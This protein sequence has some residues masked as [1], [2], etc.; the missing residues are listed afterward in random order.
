MEKADTVLPQKD[1]RIVWY[2]R[3]EGTIVPLAMKLQGV[4]SLLPLVHDPLLHN[5]FGGCYQRQGHGSG[6]LPA[7]RRR[8]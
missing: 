3:N 8:R 4:E 5:T 2:H 1:N 7:R 6:R